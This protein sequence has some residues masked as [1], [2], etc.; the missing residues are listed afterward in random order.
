MVMNNDN[1]DGHEVEW[2]SVRKVTESGRLAR[3][4]TAEI[5]HE[6]KRLSDNAQLDE[7]EQGVLVA[8]KWA[9]GERKT[10]MRPDTGPCR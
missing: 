5:R 3:P 10:L 4:S 9:L 2:P 8:L 7:F 1:S 6:M